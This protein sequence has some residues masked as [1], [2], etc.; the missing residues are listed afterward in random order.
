MGVAETVTVKKR[1]EGQ[2]RGCE[3]TRHL[4]SRAS[5]G[6]RPVLDIVNLPY[7]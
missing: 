3:G 7:P 1:T 2:P 6:R 4:V 5:D